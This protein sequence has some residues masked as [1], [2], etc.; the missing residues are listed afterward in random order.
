MKI[1]RLASVVD[2]V[3]GAWLLFSSLFWTPFPE[4]VANA[5]I[6]GASSVVLGF[7][8]RRG[9]EWCRWIVGILAIWLIASLWVIPRGS[10]SIVANHLTVGTLLF[11]FSVLP[12]GRGRATGEYPL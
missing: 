12:T 10:P 4:H 5:A 3:L 1:A 6:I 2:I 7:A 9:H 11:G 8:A